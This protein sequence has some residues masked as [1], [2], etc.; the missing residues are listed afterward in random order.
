[1]SFVS[2]KLLCI[3]IVNICN[4]H[5]LCN[6]H[7]LISVTFTNFLI[8]YDISDDF[9]L[10]IDDEFVLIILVEVVERSTNVPALIIPVLL[11]SKIIEGPNDK[12]SLLLFF[13]LPLD[14]A[15][16]IVIPHEN[17]L[18]LVV[19]WIQDHYILHV[20]VLVQRHQGLSIELNAEIRRVINFYHCKDPLFNNTVRNFALLL[21]LEMEQ[22][23]FPCF[24]RLLDLKVAE[25]VFTDLLDSFPNPGHFLHGDHLLAVLILVMQVIVM[26]EIQKFHL[27]GCRRIYIDH[28]GLVVVFLPSRD[29][30]WFL[31]KQALAVR[32]LTISILLLK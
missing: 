3:W 21:L 10:V 27:V 22:I 12:A 23:N 30:D 19:P 18:L 29:N 13:R 24:K 15:L 9:T 11:H 5:E 4:I 6:C 17:L 26:V 25:I 14:P 16:F 32:N 20:D 7:G 28:F 1:M 8:L 2:N 31:P